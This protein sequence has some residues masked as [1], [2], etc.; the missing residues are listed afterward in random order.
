[1]HL[2]N[3]FFAEVQP[4]PWRQAVDRANMMLVLACRSTAERVYGRALQQF[5]A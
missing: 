5:T 2:I 3:V 1:V 4:V